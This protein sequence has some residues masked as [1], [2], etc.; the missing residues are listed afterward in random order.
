MFAFSVFGFDVGPNIKLT[1]INCCWG[2]R[3][4]QR[5]KTLGLAKPLFFIK[6]QG[7]QMGANCYYRV[8]WGAVILKMDE[9][10]RTG[11]SLASA[12]HNT[13]MAEAPWFTISP[14][15]SLES[16]PRLTLA[17]SCCNVRLLE[18][19][20]TAPHPASADNKE[21]ATSLRVSE[22]MDDQPLGG[23]S[24]RG[25][26]VNHPAGHTF[27][28]SEQNKLRLGPKNDAKGSRQNSFKT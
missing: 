21:S 3:R 26:R 4:Y 19:G 7:F 14:Q 27:K 9:R 25:K 2:V 11:R 12:I 10:A 20:K 28:V 18:G 13:Q 22:H 17:K 23:P 6:G 16:A 15:T 24:Q 8:C 1:D 5:E